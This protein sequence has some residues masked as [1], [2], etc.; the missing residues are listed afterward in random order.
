MKTKRIFGAA[1][2]GEGAVGRVVDYSEMHKILQGAKHITMIDIN[3]VLGTARQTHTQTRPQ[4]NMTQKS[5]VKALDS[6]VATNASKSATTQRNKCHMQNVLCDPHDLCTK[7]ENEQDQL[8]FKVFRNKY[9]AMEELRANNHMHA[10]LKDTIRYTSFHPLTGFKIETPNKADEYILLYKKRGAPILYALNN[11]K[12]FEK[13]SLNFDALHETLV[14]LLSRMHKKGWMHCDIKL[15]N[16][17]FADPSTHPQFSK[18]QYSQTKQTIGGGTFVQLFGTCGKIPKVSSHSSSS[19]NIHF[20]VIDFGLA[21]SVTTALENIQKHPDRPGW[22]TY[23]CPLLWGSQYKQT[24]MKEV[25]QFKHIGIDAFLYHI[26]GLQRTYWIFGQMRSWEPP[27]SMKEY[28]EIV[29]TK[30][31]IKNLPAIDWYSLL[32][33]YSA[34]ECVAV[35]KKNNDMLNKVRA[36]MREVK[37]LLLSTVRK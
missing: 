24:I 32:Y 13:L 29:E 33:L 8:V 5:L 1:V 4:T 36:C 26:Q 31:S 15:E 25:R 10:V 21:I 6:F 35:N 34:I 19:S 30:P 3:A 37:K 9:D 12:L 7:L 20:S 27:L 23:I 2:L 28:L 11:S 18:P 16:I 17:L 14:T 22:G